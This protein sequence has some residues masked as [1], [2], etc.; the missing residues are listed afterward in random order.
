MTLEEVAPPDV[1]VWPEN[2]LAVQVFTRL[3]T[4]WRTGMN[5]PTGL[6]YGAIPMVLELLDVP[7]SDWQEVFRGLQVMEVAALACMRERTDGRSNQANA[8][9]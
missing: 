2:W 9:R 3:M 8:S 1:E 4:Q 5:G 7:R 6:D